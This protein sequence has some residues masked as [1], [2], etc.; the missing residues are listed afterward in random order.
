LSYQWRLNG[1][2][3]VGAT[4]ATLSLTSVTTG[5]SGGS[6]SCV[7][8]N[9]AGSVTS[10]AAIFTVNAAPI[11]PTITTQPVSRSVTAG[12]NVSFTV[13]ASG[14]APL[15]YQWRLNGANLAGATS[16]TLTLTSV[17]TGQSGGSYS[18][19][20]SNV[21]GTATSSVAVLTV[22]AAPVAPTITDATRSADGH[23]RATTRASLCVASGTAPLSYQWRLNGANLAGATSAT[24]TLSA[25]SRVDNLAASYSCFVSNVAG[26]ATSSAAVLDGECGGGCADH[27]DAAGE[28]DGDCGNQREFHRRRDR[29]GAPQLSMAISTA[30]TLRARRVRR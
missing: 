23:R 28:P 26:T 7:V 19:L 1:A 3:I 14:T 17:T 20:V 4:S 11:A 18:C 27:H 5:Q 6:Y 30:R 9:V 10:S 29:H 16:A 22:N 12:T 2:N 15:S 24:L 21:A 13:A 8:T 25:V